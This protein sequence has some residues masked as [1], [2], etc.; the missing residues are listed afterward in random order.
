[1][2]DALAARVEESYAARR[3][4]RR[5]AR[6]LG[7]IPA[8][9]TT[10]PAGP[11]GVKLELTYRCNL[12]C[13]FCYT[14][15]PRR[16]R[17]KPSDLDDADWLRVVDEAVELGAVEAVVTGGEPLLRRDLALEICERLARAGLGVTMNTNGW[18]VD[19]A[20][21]DRLAAC[22]GFRANVSIDGSTAELHDAARGVPGSWERAVKA[23]DRLLER[24][25]T[26][27]IVH[28]VTPANERH[29]A[30]F[31]DVARLLGAPR[32]RLAIVA[33]YGA[34]ARAGD[35]RT[36]RSRVRR[37]VRAFQRTTP[38][39]PAIVL[40]PGTLAGLASVE[41]DAPRVLLV[42]PNGAVRI[43][44]PRPFAFGSVR[45][46]D[47]ATCWA[48]IAERWNDERVVGWARSL[49]RIGDLPQ[50]SV[51]P[52]LDDEVWLG[53]EPP[54]GET[55]LREASSIPA[56]VP[57]PTSSGDLSEARRHVI[58]LALARRYA[59][60]PVRAS[61][62]GAG[63]RYVRVVENGRV[64]HVNRTAALVM[65]ACAPGSPAAAVERLRARHPG[66][67]PE[68]LAVD[69]LASARGLVERGILMPAGVS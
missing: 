23:V 40:R 28:V 19:G 37:T 63:G 12:Q 52:Y 32:V 17:E 42:R 34:A 2:L 25:V 68:R 50:A 64:C 29:L 57:R 10:A 67:D 7:R 69:V 26:V 14:D 35:W 1:V 39:A 49:G 24:G 56:G 3:L 13:P 58:A 11:V 41:E 62:D 5:A 54:P 16:T 21:A 27:E 45:T 38:D 48:R 36:D 15:S 4:A 65:D 6:R 30:D 46:H 20:V 33:P 60:G 66:A 31:L 43:D 53:D 8:A 55:A 61:D 18:F 22:P 9:C 47:L 51:V 59:A 44:S